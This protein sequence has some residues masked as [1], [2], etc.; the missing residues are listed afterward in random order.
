M[1]DFAPAFS[2]SVYRGMVA[3]NAV[4]GTIV[5][6][7]MANDSDPAGTPAGLVRYKVDQDNHPYSTSIFDVADVSGQVVTKVNLNEEPNLKFRLVVVAYDHGEPVKENTTLV[8][9]T[10]LQPSVIPVF[11]QEEYRFPPVSEEAAV[12][13]LVGVIMAAAVNQTIVYSIVGG[14]GGDVFS[15]N[16]I[17]GEIFTASLLDYE[18]VPKYVLKVEANSMEVVSFNLR[19]PSKSNTAKVVVD[20]WDENDH[21]PV[22][23]KSLY[24]GG[25][26]EDA[27]TFTPVLQ[28]QALDKDTGNYS[29]ML[30]SLIIPPPPNKGDSKDG[31]VIEPYSGVVKTAIVY[32]NMRRS[33]FKF[34]VVATDN[35]GLGHSSTAEIVVS[36]VN[37]LDMQ[38]IVSNVPP[39]Y[40]E[41]NKDKLLSILERYV[42]EQVAGAKVVV[43]TIGPHRTIDGSE[44]EDYTKSDLMIYA[45]DPLTNRAISR[46]E[47]FKFLDGKLLDIN[48]ESQPFLP[49]GG[50]ILEITTPEVVTSVKKAVQSVGYTEGALLALAVIII[51]C[52]VP[53]ILIVIITYKQFKER[54]AECAKT[55]R[56]QMALPTGKPE[57]GT[58]NNL[59]EELGDNAMRGF[60][61]HETQHL[62]RPSLLRPEE[63]S[64]ESG[65][66]PGQ[67]YYTQDYY[68]YDH[69]YELPQYGSRRKLISPSGLYDEYGEVVVDDDGSYY[70]SPQESDGEQGS[71]K[72][73]IKLVLDREYETSSTGEDSI[74][75]TQRNRLS[76]TQTNHVNVNGSIYV[77][78]NGS[79]IR[80]RRSGNPSGP[81][82]TTSTTNNNLKVSSP[83]FSSRLAKHFKKLD[84]MAATMEERAPLNSPNT[85]VDGGRVTLSTFQSSRRAASSTAM[86]SFSNTDNNK[87]QNVL[88]TRQSSV[89]L[90]S[91]S[92]SNTGP[93]SVASKTDVPTAACSSTEQPESTA[94]TDG[95]Q[96]GDRESKVDRDKDD[97]V[98]PRET[99]ECPSD[100]TQSDEEELW[101][102]PW[103]SLHIPMTK[104]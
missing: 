36:V 59:Y 66:D 49:P 58:A 77:A 28:V 18:T 102:G 32:R 9:I 20:V 43:E 78:Q 15:L 80:T 25:V 1:N 103:N 4:K 14:N 67:D 54:Q 62:L 13:T 95:L 16:E 83:V 88:N 41:K 74:P 47:L 76:T 65:I 90:G 97:S 24:I 38:V 44:Q 21:P 33:Y 2:Q 85:S 104:L 52:C 93:G 31:F 91:T 71:R 100:R 70:Y 57:G 27:K 87:M 72:R 29:A 48:K 99:L 92:T 6:T 84:K 75:D 101:M 63:L 81:T 60:G 39:T 51:I 5:T 11:T 64:V 86:S 73:R 82:H 46:Q 50:R 94:G 55:S 23:T 17:T 8:E 7:V 26:T 3:P 42:Q 10:V 96:E 34:E 53:A 68:N 40:V 12:G 19:A 22:F 69:G 56:I 79:I 89:S 61:Q 30:Y 45:I 35:Y 37:Q 98:V